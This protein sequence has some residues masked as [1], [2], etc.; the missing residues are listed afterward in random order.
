MQ[1]KEAHFH[2]SNKKEVK[3][4]FLGSD[5]D[6]LH[7]HINQLQTPIGVQQHALLRTTDIIST[8]FYDKNSVS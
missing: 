1:G 2:L 8:T 4:T 7:F 3:G 5:V 6:V